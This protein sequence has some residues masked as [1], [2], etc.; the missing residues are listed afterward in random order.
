MFGCA[1]TLQE[2]FQDAEVRGQWV[3]KFAVAEDVCVL[4]MSDRCRVLMQVSLAS[5]LKSIG[6]PVV[7]E[8][9]RRLR[10]RL[11]LANYRDTG[12]D[13]QDLSDIAAVRITCFLE[14]AEELGDLCVVLL[15]ALLLSAQVT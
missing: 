12:V 4:D 1:D 9:T 11:A 10:L 8:M 2:A 15:F 5:Y 14:K 3:S 13:V 6:T 7:P